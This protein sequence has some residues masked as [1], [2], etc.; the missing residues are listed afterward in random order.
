MQTKDDYNANKARPVKVSM[1]ISSANPTLCHGD[2]MKTWVGIRYTAHM[3]HMGVAYTD[4]M[5]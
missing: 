1:M 5:C 2:G 3:L 4:G